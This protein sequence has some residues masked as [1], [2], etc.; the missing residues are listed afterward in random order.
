[1]AI[2]PALGY[3]YFAVSLGVIVRAQLLH[4][5][6]FQLVLAQIATY[7][8]LAIYLLFIL[9]RLARRSLRELGIRRPTSRELRTAVAAAA[10]MWVVVTI[11]STAMVAV[12]HNRQ[13]EAALALLSA[14]RTPFHRVVFVSVALI[15]APLVEELLFR[16]FL[17]NAFARYLSTGAAAVASGVLF[18]L[19]HISSA[20]QLLTVAFPLAL[21]GVVL[22]YAYARTRCYWV[23][24]IA[25]ALFN[26]VSIVGIFVFHITS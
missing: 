5:P 18:G 1:M 4:P 19:L 7:G 20:T 12:T 9:P 24:V 26:S 3:L 23:N 22:A 16:V 14:L 2:F 17:F 25:H 13:P 10:I 15:L 11:S 8:P 21:G 6:A